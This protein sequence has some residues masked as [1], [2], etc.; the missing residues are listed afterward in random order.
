MCW[1]SIDIEA[2][3]PIPSEYSMISI[4]AVIIEDSLEKTFY[5]ELKPVSKNF[6]PES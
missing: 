1:V 6:V 5:A 3:G 4:G 2:D